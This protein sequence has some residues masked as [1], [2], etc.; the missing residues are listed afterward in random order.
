MDE[1]DHPVTDYLTGRVIARVGY[2]GD[3]PLEI[4]CEDGLVVRVDRD[5]E[6]GWRLIGK[7]TVEV[8]LNGMMYRGM[9]TGLGG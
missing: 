8:V 4:H 5:P 9:A 2:V 6:G 1:S 3:G 7:P